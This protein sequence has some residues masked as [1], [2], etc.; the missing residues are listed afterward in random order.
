[1]RCLEVTDRDRVCIRRVQGDVWKPR[2]D[3]SLYR[4]SERRCLED[5]DRESLCRYKCK[6]LLGRHGL[7]ESV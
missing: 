4:T 3:K 2:T 5:S 1:M 7:I 6:K